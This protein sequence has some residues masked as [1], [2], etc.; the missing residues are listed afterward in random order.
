MSLD[1]A[2]LTKTLEDEKKVFISFKKFDKNENAAVFHILSWA[3]AQNDLLFLQH[4]V[5]TLLKEVINNG[6]KANFKRIYFE[7]NSID[8]NNEKEYAKAME[9]FKTSVIQ[10]KKEY[11][12]KAQNFNYVVEISTQIIPNDGIVFSVYNNSKIT[13]EEIARVKERINAA[14]KAN[15]IIEV[16][17]DMTD[18]IEG[19]GLGLILNLM[20]LKSS[21]IGIKN[22]QIK[23]EKEGTRVNIKVP[24]SIHKPD[25]ISKI[26]KRIIAEIDDVPTFSDSIQ[27]IIN[28]CD[29]PDSSIS[30][31]A[32]EIGKDPS[33]S[34]NILKLANSA[35]LATASRSDTIPMAAAKIGIKGIKEM[36]IAVAARRVLSE[37]YK[38]IRGFWDHSNL[39]AIYAKKIANETGM[40][41]MQDTI[42]L[43][44]LLHDI[45]KLVLYSIEPSTVNALENAVVDKNRT[46]SALFEEITMGISHTDIGARLSEKWNFSDLLTEC[47][48]NHH[49]PQRSSEKFRKAT[50]IIHLADSFLNIEEKNSNYVYIDYSARKLLNLDTEEKLHALHEKIKPT[51]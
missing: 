9:S 16:L 41:K 21:G 23:A 47:I 17:G 11:D 14:V 50:C 46:D 48:R 13:K 26:E 44:G 4:I 31:I 45:G 20:L 12:E 6:I 3:L 15:S 5:L 37:K 42:Y 33:L 49:F 19:A 43:A 24:L 35:A 30:A 2:Q 29:S 18:D 51:E 27:K 7:E 28:L 34:S 10:K 25:T 8:I 36:T 38:E 22:F 40:K 1:I 32:T 39:C